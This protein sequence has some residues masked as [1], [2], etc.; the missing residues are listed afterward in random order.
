MLAS[1]FLRQFGITPLTAL[2]YVF[3]QRCFEA[4]C[5]GARGFDDEVRRRGEALGNAGPLCSTS[6]FRPSSGRCGRGRC[7]YSGYWRVRGRPV[8]G[9]ADA[10]GSRAV[11]YAGAT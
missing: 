3:L 7:F 2:Q 4:W 8:A 5:A 6:Q 9:W 1:Q 10:D 11:G